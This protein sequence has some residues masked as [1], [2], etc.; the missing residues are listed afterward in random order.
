MSQPFDLLYGDVDRYPA[1]QRDYPTA[2]QW[3]PSPF[4]YAQEEID[5]INRLYGWERYRLVSDSDIKNN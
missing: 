5:E 3:H 1:E 2:T 4:Q